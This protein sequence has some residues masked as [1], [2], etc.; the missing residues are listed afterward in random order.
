MILLQLCRHIF[1]TLDAWILVIFPLKVT[2]VTEGRFWFSGV[3][4]GWVP[5][6]LFSSF[7]FYNI[8]SKVEFWRPIIVWA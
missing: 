6:K 8:Q 3:Q 7:H 4:W 2:I 1:S 5:S